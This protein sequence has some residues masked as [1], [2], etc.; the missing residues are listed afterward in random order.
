[1]KK[2]LIIAY[3]WPPAGGAGVQRVLKYAKYLPEFGW[4]PVILTVNSPDSPIEDL[5]LLDDISP[6]AKIYKTNALEPFNLYKKITGKK[7]DDKISSDI[8][9]DETKS[10]FTEKISRWIRLNIFI[11]DAK[12]GWIP[13]AIRRGMK[14]IEE[15]NI[16]LI[17]SSSPPHTVQV[18][19]KKL[20]HKSKLKW[21]ADFRDPWLELIHYQAN[22]RLKFV[23][24]YEA[25]LEKKVLSKA[26]SLITVS[27][28][29]KEMF[30]NK[31]NRSDVHVI[32]NGFDESDIKVSQSTSKNYFIITY[33]GIISDTKIPTPLFFA[34]NKMKS[35]GI[36]NIK[37]IFAGSICEKCFEAVKR[38]DLEETFE[39]KGYLPHSESVKLLQE[40]TILLLLIDDIPNNKGIL[41]GKL[42]EYLGSKKPIFAIG[43]TDGD[44]NKIIEDTNSGNMVE[45]DQDEEAYLLLKKMYDGWINSD[46]DYKFNVKQYSRKKQA[47]QLA[48][49]F[50][51]HF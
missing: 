29:I 31:V 46:L 22:K 5:S 41:T 30:Y 3:Y 7:A 9:V 4:E 11:P 14:I 25:K 12:I 34:V 20:A 32:P 19:A 48:K 16:E 21:V 23:Q 51:S 50:N 45:F 27:A 44:A 24:S 43:P 10:S 39:Y 33:T 42:F 2:V 17:F 37:L 1:M 47:E 49:I 26:D 13:Y 35:E 36:K 40:A 6:N 18:I 8:L 15:E 28:A 38:F